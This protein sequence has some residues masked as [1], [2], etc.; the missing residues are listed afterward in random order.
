MRLMSALT[1]L[2]QV[3]AAPGAAAKPTSEGSEPQQEMAAEPPPG[4]LVV[5]SS[6]HYCGH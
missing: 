1:I 3:A 4:R 6:K 2:T 5:D